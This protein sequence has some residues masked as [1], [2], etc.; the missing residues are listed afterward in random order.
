MRLGQQRQP[1]VIL[2]CGPLAEKLHH[3]G[4]QAAP[5]LFDTTSVVCHAGAG[6]WI[7]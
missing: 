3:E 4:F 1:N 7:M 5:T 2:S 6:P